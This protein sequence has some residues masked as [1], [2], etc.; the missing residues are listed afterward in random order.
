MLTKKCPLLFLRCVLLLLFVCYVPPFLL[1]SFSP[2]RT[3]NY[4]LKLYNARGPFGQKEEKGDENGSA[5]R[6]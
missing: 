5:D 1:N 2:Y 4:V 3:L 6:E